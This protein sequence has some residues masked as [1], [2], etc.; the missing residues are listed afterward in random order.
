MQSGKLTGFAQDKEG[1]WRH[2]G[3][4]CVPEGDNLWDKILEEAHKSKFTVNPAINNMYQDLKK[5]F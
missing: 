4:I 2:Q 1:I 5:M 3:R